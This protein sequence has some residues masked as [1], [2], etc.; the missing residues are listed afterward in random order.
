MEIFWPY[1]VPLFTTEDPDIR[2]WISETYQ[3]LY[4]DTRVCFS[5]CD[6][7]VALW[8]EEEEQLKQ[9]DII[10]CVCGEKDHREQL[11]EIGG[12]RLWNGL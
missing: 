1:D 5:T 7:L 4:P 9:H 8:A 11:H 12:V 10:F 2:R 6:E 3:Q